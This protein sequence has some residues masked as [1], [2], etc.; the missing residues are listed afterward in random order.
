MMSPVHDVIYF[1]LTG[2][3]I[4]TF[5]PLDAFGTDWERIAFQMAYIFCFILVPDPEFQYELLYI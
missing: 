2:A 5:K 1:S 3:V 4:F